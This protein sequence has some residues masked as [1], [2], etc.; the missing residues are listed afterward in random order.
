MYPPLVSEGSAVEGGRDTL[1]RDIFRPSPASPHSATHYRGITSCQPVSPRASLTPTTLPI[2]A[3]TFVRGWAFSIGVRRCRPL[4]K[5]WDSGKIPT[6]ETQA[7][8]RTLPPGPRLLH[9]YGQRRAVWSNRQGQPRRA[10]DLCGSWNRLR[11]LPPNNR[12]AVG[13]V[14]HQ[15]SPIALSPLNG[16]QRKERCLL[17]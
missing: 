14:Q 9:R 4:V 15:T 11:S 13:E 12:G 16:A 2:V 7:T 5:P 1:L 10:S 6:H 17:L 8:L 3:P